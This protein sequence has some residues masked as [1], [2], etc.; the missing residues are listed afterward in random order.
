[1]ATPLATA[2]VRI[3]P[4]TAGFEKDTERQLSSGLDKAGT[5]LGRR[6]GES[7]A[8]SL[9]AALKGAGAD[10]ADEFASAF[11]QRVQDKTNDVLVG[12]DKTRTRRQGE[13]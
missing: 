9:G 6:L 11:R 7:L 3:R 13:E 12:P 1:M 4:E 5:G 8:K 10:I 2:F